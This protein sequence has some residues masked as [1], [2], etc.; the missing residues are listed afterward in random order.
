MS[1]EEHIPIKNIFH[2]LCYAWNVLDQNKILEVNDWEVEKPVDL[3]ARVLI[4][5]TNHLLKYGIGKE[6]KNIVDSTSSLRGKIDILSS[7]RR[8]LPKHGKAIC[9]Y[10][11]LSMNNLNN[12]IIKATLSILVKDKQLDPKLKQES[13]ILIK[14]LQQVSDIQLSNRVFKR[15]SLN[16]HTRIYRLILNVCDLVY[17]QSLLNP[18]GSKFKFMDFVRD[19][20]K[21]SVVYEKFL[22]NFFKNNQTEF[23]VTRERIYWNASSE[24]DPELALLPT[25]LTDITLRSPN[26]TIVIDAKYYRKTLNDFRGSKKLHSNNLYQM[27]AYLRNM[28]NNKKDENAEGILLYPVINESISKGYDMSG[29]SIQ[30]ETIDLMKNWEVIEKDLLSILA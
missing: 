28:E 17:R 23:L 15:I 6:Y 16:S 4:N 29:K 7:V 8:M 20:R 26:R 11:E 9:S 13:I 14:K 30:I 10:D 5:G 2:M 22:Y 27:F 25:M 21:M 1:G 24:D 19:D 3:F 12:Q 18:D